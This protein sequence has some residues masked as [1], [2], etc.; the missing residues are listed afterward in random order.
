MAFEKEICPKCGYDR[1]PHQH[2]IL[3][4]ILF[5]KI[6]FIKRLC[7]DCHTDYHKDLGRKSL[8]R[9]DLPPIFYI[10]HFIKWMA[11]GTILFLIIKFIV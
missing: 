3:P 6:G 7:H 9:T 1:Y 10:K 5:G 4:K 2:H 11:V 8:F